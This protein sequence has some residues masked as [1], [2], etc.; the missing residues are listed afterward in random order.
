MAKYLK[1][2]TTPWNDIF[3]AQQGGPEARAKCLELL[4]EKYYEPILLFIK[5]TMKIQAP[6][7][8]DD[9][10]QS[11]FLKKFLEA[12]RNGTTLLDVFDRSQGRVRD[13]LATAVRNFVRDEMRRKKAGKSPDVAADVPLEPGDDIWEDEES[14][15]A[16]DI[17]FEAMAQQTWK[18]SLEAFRFECR[19]HGKMH[20]YEIFMRHVIDPDA[21][22]NP[23]R[24]DTAR[25]LNMDVKR[26]ENCR[27]NAVKNFRK[28]FRAVVRKTVR[29]DNQ[30]DSEIK[31]ILHRLGRKA[32]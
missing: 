13:L 28:T 5:L 23:R 32:G 30:V 14:K 1:D 26:M 25:A 22:G 20:Y 29:D 16:E 17:F 15:Q 19:D 18:D 12:N 21:Y 3:L 27:S 7:E 11:F 6:Q 31:D 8:A 10:T 4:A 9:L 2:V 24:E